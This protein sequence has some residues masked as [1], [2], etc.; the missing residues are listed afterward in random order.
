MRSMR[1]HFGGVGIL[2]AEDVAGELDDHALHAKAYAEVRHVVLARILCAYK[3]TL[4]SAHAETAGH[5]YA[6]DVA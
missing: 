2:K 6:V 1:V 3:H 4:N 5:D